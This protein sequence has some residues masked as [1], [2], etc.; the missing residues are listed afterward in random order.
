MKKLLTLLFSLACLVGS[1]QNVPY[2]ISYQAIA[3]DQNGQPIPGIDI[4]G[5]PIDDAE[6][7]VRFTILEG[8]A[9]GPEIYQE[10]HEVLTD[11][12]GMFQLVV[13]QGL[14]VSSDAFSEID[15]EGEKFLKVEISIDNNSSFE[16]SAVQQLMSVPYSFLAQDVINNDD[17][18]AD[19][20]NE[21]QTLSIVGDSVKLTEGGAIRLP[22]DPDTDPVNEIQ[23]ISRSGDTVFLSNGGS[24]VLPVDPDLDST[25]EIQFL[26]R[27]G[28]TV[29]LTDGGS[30]ILPVDPDL[31]STNEIQFLSRAG[32]T[33]YLTDGG[34]FVLPVDPDLDSTNEIQ[35]LSRVGDTVYLTDGGSFVL[36]SD[37]DLDSTNEIQFLGRVGDTVYLTNG[38]SFVLPVDPDLDSTNELQ[39][40]SYSSDTLVLDRGGIALLPFSTKAE[41]IDDLTDARNSNGSVGLGISALQNDT[42]G[43]NTAVGNYTQSQTQSGS[44]N[45]SMGV[46]ALN[47]NTSGGGN[48]ALG[49]AT[50]G[51]NTVGNSNTAVGLFALAGWSGATTGYANTGVGSRPLAHL[52]TGSTNV[53]V[54]SDALFNLKTGSNNIALGDGVGN[55]V[56]SGNNNIFIG[57]FSNASDSAIENAVAIGFGAQ[58]HESATI[59]LGNE[60][61]TKVS[62]YADFYGKGGAFTDST[63]S[64]NAIVSMNSNTKGFLPPRMTEVERD[65]ISNPSAGLIIYCTD[66]GTGEIQ[67]FNGVNWSSSLFSTAVT[68]PSV[69]TNAP[70]LASN[71]QV[72]I[73]GTVLTDGGTNLTRKGFVRSTDPTFST[74]DTIFIAGGIGLYLSDTI[75]PSF[76]TTYYYKAFAEN[77]VGR[78]FGYVSSYYLP[79][80]SSATSSSVV[81]LD[82]ISNVSTQSATLYGAVVSA[83]GTIVQ[84]GFVLDTLPQPTIDDVVVSGGTQLGNFNEV[85]NGLTSNGKTY[86]VRS[87]LIT[88]VDTTY[89]NQLSF[90]TAASS[91]YLSVGQTFQGGIIFYLADDGQSGLI[92]TASNIG[93]TK[94]GCEG[95]EIGGTS[96]GLWS[97]KQNTDRILSVCSESNTAAAMCASYVY[98]GYDDWY[99]PSWDELIVMRQNLHNNGIGNFSW[100]LWSSS[101]VD[102]NTANSHD[103]SCGAYLSKSSQGG[104]R[105]VRT[106]TLST[107]TTSAP[108]LA[109]S[110]TSSNSF[111]SISVA[112]TISGAKANKVFETGVVYSSTNSTPTTS[113]NLQSLSEYAPYNCGPTIVT[114]TYEGS[115]FLGNVQ[116]L[117]SNTTYY[118]RAYA[119][120]PNGTY[121]S[122]AETVETDSI[123]LAAGSGMTD[124]DGNTY[125]SIIVGDME[126]SVENLRVSKFNNGDAIPYVANGTSWTST[127]TSAYT[128]YS[129]DPT[130]NLLFGKWYNWF[131]I[132][133][134]RGLCPTG[135]HVATNQEWL[136]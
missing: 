4:V 50:L 56:I 36:P 124:I 101:E 37:P 81:T 25:N 108:T 103:M 10:E 1:A 98:Q 38:G 92:V 87:Y 69:R 66:C 57:S 59:Q 97:G 43:N 58:V 84:R 105:A 127:S 85:K 93:T 122:S 117:S 96:Q 3:L 115:S 31:D 78:S 33:V 32:D 52:T 130:Y 74:G 80:T 48:T 40:I 61:M 94:F 5:R 128:Y 19:P 53:A 76:N 102:A 118:M 134:S 113:D 67:S 51:N 86:Y 95:T 111:N 22:I 119:K 15:W 14:Q 100:W 23:F 99:L 107:S 35:F 89:S 116:G 136:D 68:E 110:G 26:S 135:W 133:D 79:D 2:G 27:A 112:G 62:T 83:N 39:T 64:S 121:Y 106:F 55:G 13:G 54:G 7:G 63:T 18:D 114:S 75:T 20:T 24:F 47:Q 131:A 12:Y 34:S 82:S 88:S 65:L 16:L 30:F 104:V 60:Y 126:W 41:S 17:A 11:L 71:H 8:S 46:Y 42:T 6:I 28:D 109:I 70:T 49:F 120:T 132:D 125:T 90:T 73:S 45:V 129:S 91:S 72:I 29:Y 44:M 21:I 123:Y 9:S 77:Q